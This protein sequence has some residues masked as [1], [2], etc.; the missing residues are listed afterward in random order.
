MNRP[1][2]TAMRSIERSDKGGY[3]VDYE[4]A[5]IG[6]RQRLHKQLHAW[7]SRI[8]C[9][10]SGRNEYT[11]SPAPQSR[12]V[13][14]DAQSLRSGSRFKRTTIVGCSNS[15]STCHCSGRAIRCPY[16]QSAL[17]ARPKQCRTEWRI[18]MLAGRAVA[19]KPATPPVP[20]RG[21]NN[22]ID[23]GGNVNEILCLR[24]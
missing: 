13:S 3:R 2:E 17:H 21:A 16:A 11:N 12:T 24:P 19:R 8:D 5:N 1:R 15:H 7:H 20:Y 4:P 14:R 23:S 22:N 18:R 10:A 6:N 9:T